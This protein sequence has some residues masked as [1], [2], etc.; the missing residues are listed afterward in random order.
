MKPDVTVRTAKIS[1]CRK[2]NFGF[3]LRQNTVDK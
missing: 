3:K 2:N 1:A